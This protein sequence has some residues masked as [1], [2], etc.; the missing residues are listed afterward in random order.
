MRCSHS[1]L[2]RNRGATLVETALVLSLLLL[3]LFGIFE[4]GRYL[5]VMQML[6]NAAREGSRYAA[7]NVDKSGSFVTT[8]E[9]GRVSIT[10]HVRQ[11]S[12][13]TDRMIENFQVRVFPCDDAGLYA[14]PPL[15]QP[16]SGSTSWNDATFTQRI[17]VEV[18]GKYRPVLPV[19]WLPG[20]QGSG[21]V[22]S[23]FNYGSE[24]TVS[25]KV[26]AVGGSE[27]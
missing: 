21:I 1:F 26:A 25:V 22:V 15:I 2:R 13:G 6:A 4:Y 16:R 19:V 23:F 8:G 3:F 27:G 20:A 5:M 17:A 12:R 11:M 18:T 24:Q 10:E 7:C 9:S 14:N